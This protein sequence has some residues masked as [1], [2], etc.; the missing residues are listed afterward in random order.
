MLI[1]A[2]IILIALIALSLPIAASLGVLGVILDRT[3]GFLPLYQAAG[4][5]SWTA[6]SGFLLMSV[7]LFVLLGEIMLRSGIADAMYDALAKWLGWLPGG[8]MHANV[9]ACALFAATSGSSVA[10]A[11]TIGTV[12]LPQIKRHGYGPRLFFGTLAAGGTLGILIPPS[13]NMIIYGILTNSSVPKLYLA[14][15]VPGL[16]LAGLFMAATIIIVLMRPE[17]AGHCIKYTFAER[18]AGTLGV[19]PP[20]LI[21][22]LV[23]GSIYG[24]IATPTEAAALGVVGALIIAATRR[25]LNWQMITES[26]EGTAVTTSMIVFIIMA[27]YFLNMILASIGLTNQLNAF[28]TGLG[29]SPMQMLLAVIVFYILLG[30]FMETLSMMIT[31]IPI[32]A[33]LMFSLGF[34]PI[35]YGVIMMILIETALI[36]PPIGLN[37]Y[38]VQGVRGEGSMKDVMIGALPF[39]GAMALMVL[40]LTL[41]PGLATWIP[42]TFAN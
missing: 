10:T 16:I 7:P 31:T 41:F 2:F 26:V 12:A 36:T 29:L 38:V 6:T 3:F 13:I 28:V 23:I 35:W 20:I 11:A 40:L 37:L 33:P 4:E 14:G 18:M 5:V 19:I 32:I 27:A 17:I 22:V 25:R 15:I 30:C 24:G 9:G 21:F 1:T 8:V 34:D 42:N 39:V